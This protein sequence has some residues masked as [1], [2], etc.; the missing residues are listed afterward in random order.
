MIRSK[1]RLIRK[2]LKS[3]IQKRSPNLLIK[4]NLRALGETKRRKD[5]RK[6][7][8]MS[9]HSIKI[10][11]MNSCKIFL[12]K[13]MFKQLLQGK[14]NEN[15]IDLNKSFN[16]RKVINHWGINI[17]KR[18]IKILLIEI[19]NLVNLQSKTLNKS[20]MIISCKGIRKNKIKRNHEFRLKDSSN[21]I[22]KEVHMRSGRN[23]TMQQMLT[24]STTH[25]SIK[26]ALMLWILNLELKNTSEW[27]IKIN[28]RSNQNEVKRLNS[29]L[30][31]NSSKLSLA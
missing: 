19:K 1:L 21:L 5:K 28:E 16:R 14:P 31:K 8:L 17:L 10:R 29:K 18:S 2:I 7:M 22:L 25:L 3:S 9:I 11:S 6:R 27:K 15:R 26:R 20:S 23:N 12:D 24:Q 4:S 13:I 30:K